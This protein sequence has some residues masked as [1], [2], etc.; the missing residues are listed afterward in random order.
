MTGFAAVQREFPAVTL[1]LELMPVLKLL[2]DDGGPW[3]FVRDMKL[4]EKQLKDAKADVL[5]VE[6]R[7]IPVSRELKLEKLI[8]DFQAK[9]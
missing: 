3:G 7:K 5:E 9:G 2:E 6:S 1:S 8:E 4:S